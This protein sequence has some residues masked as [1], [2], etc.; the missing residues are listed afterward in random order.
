MSPMCRVVHTAH[1]TPQACPLAT[2]HPL[3]QK[4]RPSAPNAYFQRSGPLGQLKGGSNERSLYPCAPP[5][6]IGTPP[7]H[8]INGGS[9]SGH[10]HIRRTRPEKFLLG[11]SISSTFAGTTALV[12]SLCPADVQ[13]I[14]YRPVTMMSCVQI[15]K[16]TF[17]PALATG[18]NLHA[19]NDAP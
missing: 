12:A 19:T 11:A 10:C 5:F 14:V 7:H 6:D 18:I 17:L 1:P 4:A 8:H 2:A 3:P 13:P 15:A 16:S 9:Q